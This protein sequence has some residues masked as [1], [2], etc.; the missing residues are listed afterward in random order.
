MAFKRANFTKKVKE[1]EQ[2]I[3]KKLFIMGDEIVSDITA[4][5]QKGKD[6]NNSSFK[7][8]SKNYAKYKREKYGSSK[9]NL[10]ASNNMLNSMTYKP[11]P[12]GL[13]IYFSTDTERK[14][15]LVNIK[16]GYDFFGIDKVQKKYINK[17]LKN[18]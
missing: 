7:K 17:R 11:I 2:K 4:R 14:K 3:K 5:T 18:V 15:A 10:T 13:R 12:N 1:Q 8:Y 16:R 9:P 6:K